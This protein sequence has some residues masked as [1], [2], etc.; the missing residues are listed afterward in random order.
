MFPNKSLFSQTFEKVAL[1]IKKFLTKEIFQ[2]NPFETTH[3]EK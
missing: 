3:Y 1:K 2:W